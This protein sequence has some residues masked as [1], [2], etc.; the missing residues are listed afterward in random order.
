[1][2]KPWSCDACTFENAAD[3]EACEVCGAPPGGVPPELSEEAAPPTPPP[4]PHEEPLGEKWACP[5]CTFLNAAEV[6]QCE[7]CDTDPI[8][9]PNSCPRG[10]GPRGGGPDLLIDEAP[11][12]GSP[13]GPVRLASGLRSMLS[14]GGSADPTAADPFPAAAPTTNFDLDDLLG[15]PP[16]RELTDSAAGPGYAQASPPIRMS[17]GDGSRR[18]SRPWPTRP[19][20]ARFPRALAAARAS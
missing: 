2:R 10:G 9:P 16:S 7:I 3:A 14:G 17:S 5:K 13:P 6:L 19:V 12:G 4:P 8:Q 20:G 18:E 11:E 1:V 15:G